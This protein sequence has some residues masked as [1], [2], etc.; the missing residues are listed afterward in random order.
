[1]EKYDVC[2]VGAGAVGCA[3]ARE[4]ALSYSH[5]SI[6]VLEKHGEPAMET[7]G[8]NS[9]VLHTGF[10][11]DPKSLKSVF[12]QK[13]SVIARAFAKEKNIPLLENGMLIAISSEAIHEGLL[14][15]GAALLRLII[16]GKKQKIDFKFLTRRG[17]KKLEPHIHAL[18]GIFIPQVAVIDSKKFVTALADDA[19]SSGVSFHYRSKVASVT[20]KPQ[21]YIISTREKDF[22]ANA[23]V[24]AAGLF[25]DE[26][27]RLA[28]IKRY[29]IYPWRGEYYEMTAGKRNLVKR[30]IYPAVPPHSPSK[31]IHFSPRPDGK[32][33][34]GPNARRVGSKIDYDTNHTPPEK[35]LEAARKFIPELGL[36]DIT[37]AYSGIRA[38]LTDSETDDSD[39][40]ISLDRRD[41]PML[42]LI[43]ID[44]P[45]LSSAMAIGEFSARLLKPYLPLFN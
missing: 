8:L 14:R 25:A 19:K 28:G 17:V 20:I 37:W 40:I 7:S 44:S 30:L 16:N 45:G 4:L 32:L 31:G 35:F 9:G 12:A 41:P 6:A 15:E 10:H 3:I 2:V 36:S 22:Y 5:L 11:H 29:T 43:G 42:N 26:I 39:F 33:F 24:N 1:M 23:L 13:G 38:K 27:A 21:G 18:A 34:I